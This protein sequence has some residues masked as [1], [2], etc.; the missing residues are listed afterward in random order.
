MAGAE[1]WAD[2]RAVATMAAA[3]GAWLA[4][5]PL[6][7]WL[8]VATALGVAAG[9]CVD[10]SPVCHDGVYELDRHTCERNF[11]KQRGGCVRLPH[12]FSA[13]PSAHRVVK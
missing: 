5:L 3:R 12:L 4:Q 6:V 7:A 9:K 2:G 1:R 13:L 11:G 10:D 8:V